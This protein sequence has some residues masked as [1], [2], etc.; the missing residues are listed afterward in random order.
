M[1]GFFGALEGMLSCLEMVTPSTFEVDEQPFYLPERTKQTVNTRT[2]LLGRH[3]S[4]RHIPFPLHR[5]TSR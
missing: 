3:H 1:L 2:L 5:H 4:Q